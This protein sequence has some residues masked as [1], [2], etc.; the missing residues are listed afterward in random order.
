LAKLEKYSLYLIGFRKNLASYFD[1]SP[2]N[3]S[4]GYAWPAAGDRSEHDGSG[5]GC[6]YGLGTAHYL[7]A[8]PDFLYSLSFNLRGH[9]QDYRSQT[10]TVFR[11]IIGGRGAIGEWIY[12]FTAGRN[13]YHCMKPD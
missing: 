13:L 12:A 4:Y 5:S 10:G 2:L 1:R 7:P 9:A 3:N 6:V 11:I 8:I